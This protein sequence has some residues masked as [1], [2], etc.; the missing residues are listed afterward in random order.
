MMWARA[1][2]R[3]EITLG[4]VGDTN[5]QNRDDPAAAFAR[6]RATLAGIDVMMGQMECPLTAGAGGPGPDIGFKARWRHSPPD[7]A[8]GFAEAGFR[9]VSCASNVAFPPAVAAETARHL[10]ARGIAHAGVGND[11]AAARASAIV[12]AKGLRIALLSRTSVFW[13]IEQPATEHGPG[14]ATMRGHTAYQPGRRALEMPG[15]DPVIHT[16]AGPGELAALTADIAAAREQADVVVLAMHWGL[17][18]REDHAAYRTEIGR[19]AID[20]GADL[21]YGSHSHVLGGAELYRGRPIF[22]S[23]GNFAFDWEKMRGRHRDGLLVRAVAGRDWIAH[24]ALGP[25]RRN[26]ENDVEVLSA[27]HGEGT[28]IAE[29]VLRLSDGLGAGLSI[30]GDEIVLKLS[31]KSAAEAA[32]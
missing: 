4:I 10:D 15:A 30:A 19:A 13:P 9:A 28:R 1:P 11:L 16:W 24:V 18:S 27:A 31:G 25:C 29:T 14:V 12:E 22:Y 3:G 17:S 21:V 5:V 7:V 20:A 2:R 32:E 26:D 8:R 23:L 6:V